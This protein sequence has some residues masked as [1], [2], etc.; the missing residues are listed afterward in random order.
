MGKKGRT[1]KVRLEEKD[2]PKEWGWIEGISSCQS[3]RVRVED[4]DLPQQAGI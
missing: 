3:C 1:S 4:D 2:R